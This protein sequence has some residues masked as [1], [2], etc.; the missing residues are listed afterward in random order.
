MK[1]L[2]LV[3]DLITQFKKIHIIF[4]LAFTLKGGYLIPK[5]TL[6]QIHIYMIHRDEKYFPEPNLFKPER[7]MHENAEKRHP[8]SYIPFSAGRRNCIG[9]R[10]AMMELKV[11][12]AYIIKHFEIECNQTLDYLKP[13]AYVVMKSENDILFKL[14]P[15]NI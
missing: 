4:K 14:K 12:L 1:I 15:R 5:G 7:F 2:K 8:F 11:T 6:T 9:Q 10:F 3:N 13:Y